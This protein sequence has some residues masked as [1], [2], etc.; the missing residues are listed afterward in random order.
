MDQIRAWTMLFHLQSRIPGMSVDR[1][2]V[3]ISQALTG[4]MPTSPA[5]ERAVVDAA[6][7]SGYRSGAEAG[8]RRAVEGF[9][10]AAFDAM[11]RLTRTGIDDPDAR[12]LLWAVA[13]AATV[14]GRTGPQNTPGRAR[15]S[16]HAAARTDYPD[17]S[18]IAAGVVAG[19]NHGQRQGRQDAR[20]STSQAIYAALAKKVGEHQISR[21]QID[22]RPAVDWFVDVIGGVLKAPPEEPT[23]PSFPVASTVAAAFRPLPASHTAAPTV[24][25]AA[26]VPQPASPRRSR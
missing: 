13:E 2:A 4:R 16:A 20:H 18:P 19:W 1:L 12:N 5:A 6:W 25:P 14:I 24:S 8:H 22:G 7:K 3:P 10:N 26:A 9:Q 11:S 21:T 15:E 17:L 23:L